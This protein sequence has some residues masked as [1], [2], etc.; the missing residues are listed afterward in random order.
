MGHVCLSMCMLG[1]HTCFMAWSTVQY[2]V[3]TPASQSPPQDACTPTCFI[4]NAQNTGPDHLFSESLL[5]VILKLRVVLTTYFQQKKQAGQLLV[6]KWQIPEAQSS[7]LQHKPL[8]VQGQLRHPCETGAEAAATHNTAAATCLAVGDN[9]L[10]L[11][12]WSSGASRLP[13]A[14]MKQ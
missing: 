14:T 5:R 11:C 13:P 10:C 3:N 4:G 2:L 1:Y 12:P 8:Q 6:L 7:S 9:V